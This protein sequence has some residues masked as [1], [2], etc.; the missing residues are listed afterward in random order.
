MGQFHQHLVKSYLVINLVPQVIAS[1]G[2]LASME[3]Q[4]RQDQFLEQFLKLELTFIAITLPFIDEAQ[5]DNVDKFIVELPFTNKELVTIQGLI[6]LVI[7]QQLHQL[8]FLQLLVKLGTFATQ[9]ASL[10]EPSYLVML[11]LPFLIMDFVQMHFKLQQLDSIE[12]QQLLQQQ[13]QQ[14]V[15]HHPT[16]SLKLIPPSFFDLQV[17]FLFLI[18][19]FQLFPHALI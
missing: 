19:F 17:S 16:F 2:N 5:L 10:V 14:Q 12:L 6:K 11:K 7:Q 8:L 1:L 18:R 9:M 15:L 13:S 4:Q 3:E